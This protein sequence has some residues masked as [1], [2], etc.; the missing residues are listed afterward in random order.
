LPTPS[1]SASRNDRCGGALVAVDGRTLPLLAVSISAD[2]GG[3]LARVVVEQR[4]RNAHDVP[5]T[6]TYSLPLPADAA[7]SGYAF[8]V[9]ER[10]ITGEIDKR[11]SA[12]ERFEQA[13]IEGKTAALL[14]EERSALFTQEIG[15]VP[16]G[17]DVV[18]EITIDQRLRWL[19]EG[20]WEWRFPT[21]V[22]PRF[23]GAE[24]RVADAALVSQDV[25]E[26]PMSI[27]ASL[28]LSL[29]DA[30]PEGRA[31]ESPSHRLHVEGRQVSFAAGGGEALDRDVVV[32]WP[33]AGGGVEAG[34]RA[35][36][37][38]EVAGSTLADASPGRPPPEADAFALLTIVPPAASARPET[39]PRDVIA[40]IDTSGS[41]G[42]EPLDQA[43][44][45]L[46]ALIDTL[47]DRDR[48]ELIAFSSQA[49]AWKNGP[50]SATAD[51]RRDARA[52]LAGLQ[53]G[54]GTEMYT[55]IAEALRPLRPGAQRQIVLVTDGQIGFES[56]VVA[57]IAQR[58]PAASRVHTVGVGSAV[59]RS[60]TAAA[61]RAGRGVEVIVG[62]GE[63][64]ER[65]V[66][67]IV[68]RTSAPLVV[69]V[70]LSGS[71]LVEHAPASLADV[72]AGA[73]LLVAARVRPEG[74][75]LFVRGQTASG[76]WEARAS[77]PTAAP[78]EG[79]PA[80]VALFGREA[81]EDLETRLAGGAEERVI[82]AQVEALGLRYRI[83]TRLT[84]WVAVAEEPSVDPGAPFKRER[85]PH[86]LPHGMSVAGLGLRAGAPA[87]MAAFAAAPSGMLSGKGRRV[88]PDG[89]ALPERV[90]SYVRGAIGA[91]PAARG[92][93]APT[94]AP[95]PAP[96][97]PRGGREL[98]GKATVRGN[99][100][101]IEIVVE[102]GDLQWSPPDA[103]E[104]QWADSTSREELTFATRAGVIKA[105]QS[106]RIVF[107]LPAV[108][109]TARLV[110]IE[111]GGE[112]LLV[113]L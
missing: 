105:G 54:G 108:G 82:D 78:G 20:L 110:E 57:E 61:A 81:V 103:V 39:L 22:A 11:E 55:A 107:R 76:P 28:A 65:A 41:M 111:A 53:A 37:A 4:F 30:L 62:I 12:R 17:Q 71:A 75:D 59:N 15:N 113:S 25:A 102:G 79:R 80:I 96:A 70:A 24:G 92:L 104:V 16:P 40:L 66:A 45:I 26:T 50:V 109:A 83:A 77:V 43:R 84:S 33:A 46:G 63:D 38:R 86:A 5:L 3:G 10:R 58:L 18:A 94:A 60:L 36:V 85:M 112:R 51:Q 21:T 7:V 1:D 34:L 74:G 2:G 101:D 49:R 98:R 87:P 48:L 97:A 42:G 32:R 64:V 88:P 23:L 91:P 8:R 69:D 106:L 56:Q 27:R 73:P 100:L 9:G 93:G 68:A 44:R 6:V 95:P 19:D 89:G 67:R 31:P 72:F 35:E 90:I 52:W 99:R 14:D 47:G 13:I 29:L